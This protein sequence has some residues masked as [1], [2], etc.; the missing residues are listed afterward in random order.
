MDFID[1]KNTKI[2]WAFL[3]APNTNGEYASGKY[4]VTVCLTPDQAADLKGRINARQK[5]KT[6]KDGDLVIT[7]KSSNP[8]PVKGPE[9]TMYTT[10]QSK[11]VGNGTIANVRVTL[12][13]A[14]GMT[15]AGLGAV[16]IK[17]LKVYNGGDIFAGL[18]DADTAAASSLAGL[19]DD[20]E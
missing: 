16:V 20:D 17:D 2:K 5:I 12:Y 3:G 7:V 15:F 11:K 6:D 13:E 1:I 4:E 14:R 8:P 19:D 9:G 18:D 10:E